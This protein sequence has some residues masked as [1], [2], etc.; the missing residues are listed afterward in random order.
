MFSL[1]GAAGWLP[2]PNDPDPGPG[3]APLLR[4]GTFQ[5]AEALRASAALA[6]EWRRFVR[7]HQRAVLAEAPSEV[8]P[9][10]PGPAVACRN[11]AMD[12]KTRSRHGSL[13]TVLMSAPPPPDVVSGGGRA[14]PAGGGA[15]SSGRLCPQVKEAYPHLGPFG[16]WWQQ[17]GIVVS[18][19]VEVCPS[20]PSA[21]TPARLLFHFE[22]PWGEGVGGTPPPCSRVGP[23]DE[24]CIFF[25]YKM[26]SFSTEA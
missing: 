25:S 13:Q 14:A 4:L 3:P 26:N 2:A 20:L 5:R 11:V 21:Y 16:E 1:R 17:N 15:L 6:A 18:P 22:C 19:F 8:A 9:P 10:R 12:D 23:V 24:K 7:E